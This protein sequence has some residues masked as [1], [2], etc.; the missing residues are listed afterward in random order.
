[1]IFVVLALVVIA[2]ATLW[3]QAGA[4]ASAHLG[5]CLVCGS[6]G[7]A[8]FLLNIALFMPL[9]AALA[10]QGRPAARVAWYAALLSTAIELSQFFIPGRDPSVGDVL[11]NTSGAVLG[12]LV[13]LR[14]RTWLLPAA[15]AAS[16]L[17]RAATLTA[18]SSLSQPVCC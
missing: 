12:A 3:P 5:L 2:R 14:A 10:R 4:G 17:C 6:R 1:M 13:V 18:T 16:R 9:G 7:S 11:A 8:D 15:P